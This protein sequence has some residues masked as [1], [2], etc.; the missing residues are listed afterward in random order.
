MVAKTIAAALTCIIIAATSSCTR[1]NPPRKH[2]PRSGD[3]VFSPA[4]N[5][6]CAA[7]V[8]PA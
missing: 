6:R 5:G 8:F 4:S 3:S 2:E 1:S 7:V